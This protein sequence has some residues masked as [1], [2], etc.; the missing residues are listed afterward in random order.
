MI[1]E[2]N[3]GKHKIKYILIRKNVR[4]I[5]LSIKP[6]LKIQVS[7]NHEVPIEIV[8]QFVKKKAL[9]IIKNK[10]YYEKSLPELNSEKEYVSGEAFRYLGRQ[11]RLKV[12]KSREEHIECQRTFLYLYLNDT[13]DVVIKKE[14]V[15][16]WYEERSLYIFNELLDGAYNLMKKYNI[17]KPTITIRTMKSRWGSFIPSKKNIVLNMELIYAP[18]PCIEY[19]ILHELIHLRYIRHDK[20]FYKLLNALMPDWNKRKELLDREIV[21]YL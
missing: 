9:W 11:V 14:L 7:A 6:D 10:K 12:I 5:N 1:N 16:Q 8:N 13:Q 4:N 3:Y 17:D 19:V 2:I 18:L 15:K 20:D 21:K